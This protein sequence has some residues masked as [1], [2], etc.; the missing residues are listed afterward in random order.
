MKTIINPLYV[1]LSVRLATTFVIIF[2]SIAL[3]CQIAS[4]QK[5]LP[6]GNE[7]ISFPEFV[8]NLENKNGIKIFYNPRLVEGDSIG[9]SI[10]TLPIE[11]ALQQVSV[12]K[13]LDVVLFQGNYLLLPLEVALTNLG[14]TKSTRIGIG[15]ANE[16]GRYTKARFWGRIVDGQDGEPLAGAVIY[17]DKLGIGTSSGGNGEYSL[18]LPVGDHNIRLSFIGYEEAYYPITLFSPG[19][20]NMEIMEKSH[21][22]EGVSVYARK[23]D[24][25]VSQTQMSI[26]RLDTRSIQLLP[27]SLGE[28]DV[29]KGI[30]LLP[31]VQA[32]GE[33]GSGFNV[34]GGS[35]D[36]N[37]IMIEGVPLFNSSHLF[38]LTS[39]VNPDLVNNITL[40]KGGIPS[41]FG[42]RAASVMDIKLGGKNEGK[43]HA[44]GGIGI[45]NS[46]LS[47]EAPLP[48]K[49]G[50]VII[51]GRSSYSN[52][53]LNRLPD[54]DLMNSSANFCDI[55][56][57]VNLNISKNHNLSIFGYSSYDAFSLSNEID[58]N[59]S[60][61][62]AS[63]RWNG[64][65]FESTLAS[66]AYGY[67]GYGY[68]MASNSPLSPNNS[69]KFKSN[70]QYNSLK[71]N[72]THYFTSNYSLELGFN[73][74][75]YG[76]KPGEVTPL[77]TLSTILSSS[78][79]TDQG[80]EL[81]GYAGSSITIN[82]R[83]ST[84]VGIRY[85][86]F[87][88]LGPNT[89]YIYCSGCA[90]STVNIID[91]VS[92]GKYEAN[93]NYSGFEPRMGLKF[94][95]DAS[96]SVKLSYNRTLQYINLVSNSSV[97]APSDTWYL[98]NRYIKPTL[99]EQIALGYFKNFM[100]NTV[101]TSIEL[102]YKKSK[103]NI[104]T[105]NNAIILMNRSLETELINTLG[106][107]YGIELY[108][109][110]VTGKLT[111]W[112]SYT[113]SQA[114]RRSQSLIPEEQIN[115]NAYFPSDYDKPHNLIVNGTFQITRQWRVGGTFTYSTG[116]PI[117]LPELAF[118][119]GGNQLI[120]YSDRNKY[121][122]P[123]YHRLDLSLSYDGSLRVKKKWYSY[124]TLSLVNVYSRKN[125]HS[126]F[127]QK[128]AP[129]Q[130]NNYQ[131]YA[132][133]KLTIIG[134]PLPTLTYNFNF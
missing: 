105:K 132:L 7:K 34:R 82:D 117:T 84:E 96:S 70:I 8:K 89:E 110:K 95:V 86:H 18:E 14:D 121:R 28:K 128:T 56:G 29:I 43:F 21:A 106:Y 59:Y 112:V 68:Q 26:V 13:K 108:V 100:N 120:Y 6:N 87:A 131:Q 114:Q 134:R 115:A 101:E 61:Q 35:A 44:S 91:S 113:F 119:S 30:T 48:S 97:S 40:Y 51:G 36:Q 79:A 66:V 25:N 9:Y 93:S 65:L 50:Y 45:L 107:A 98:S 63:V 41:R 127:Y 1:G 133:Y 33:F 83:L 123:E 129:S 22:I 24:S 23:S 74:I 126:V 81:A 54:E 104:E 85:S 67:S 111:G 27:T 92:Y 58:Y 60:S 16:F 88:K 11:E 2:I 71:S 52:W 118:S 62:M 17:A 80:L 19:E 78:I 64:K 20:L 90:L 39:L 49:K 32:V 99:N 57:L 5:P 75:H 55:T 103:N 15:N 73:A 46:R 72:A 109:K 3:G 37:L 47:V 31:G 10:T 69:N 38:G 77:G 122:L 125:I 130:A 116:R 76:I 53:L 12:L 42:E 94:Q 124:W 4:G 102:Y